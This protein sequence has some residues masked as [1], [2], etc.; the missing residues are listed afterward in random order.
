MNKEDRLI[1]QLNQNR[2]KLRKITRKYDRKYF[3][4]SE[5]I[6]NYYTKQMLKNDK[7]I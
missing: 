5:K 2:K 7:K 1:K 6:D 4:I 3:E